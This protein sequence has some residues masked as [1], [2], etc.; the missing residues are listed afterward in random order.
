ML[1]ILYSLS[2]HFTRLRKITEVRER[3]L[4]LINNLQQFHHM[5]F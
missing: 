5:N 2:L 1:R 3:Q 4:C